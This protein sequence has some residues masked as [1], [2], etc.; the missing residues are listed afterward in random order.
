MKSLASILC[1]GAAGSTPAISTFGRIF[2]RAFYIVMKIVAL[3]SVN[4]FATHKYP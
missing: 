4:D 1:L 2:L 3:I